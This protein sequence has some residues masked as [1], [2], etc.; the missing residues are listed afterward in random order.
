M[1]GVART[2]GSRS[3]GGDARS[4]KGR[5]RGNEFGFCGGKHFVVGDE[6]VHHCSVVCDGG[7]KVVHAVIHNFH[8]SGQLGWDCCVLGPGRMTSRMVAGGVGDAVDGSGVVGGSKVVAA[9]VARDAANVFKGKLGDH[10]DL[11]PF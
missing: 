6:R 7:G 5:V 3:L 10:E 4:S 9:V 11:L 1:V 8:E 2:G